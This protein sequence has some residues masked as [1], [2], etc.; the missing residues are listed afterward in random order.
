VPGND[1]LY[2]PG[3]INNLE[4]SCSDP[5]VF[6]YSVAGADHGYGA[7]DLEFFRGIIGDA[8]AVPTGLKV[9]DCEQDRG[10][11]H[12]LWHLIKAGNTGE[13]P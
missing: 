8:E 7:V 12:A 10:T 2:A 13:T 5:S 11:G 3:S 4:F 1:G 9:T 6:Y